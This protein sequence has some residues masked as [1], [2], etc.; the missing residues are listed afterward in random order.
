MNDQATTP[1]RTLPDGR[2]A[3]DVAPSS[4]LLDHDD[5]AT[6]YKELRAGHPVRL[7]SDGHVFIDH[8]TTG[9]AIDIADQR[10]VETKLAEMKD[11]LQMGFLVKVSPDGTITAN[12]SDNTFQYRSDPHHELSPDD[13]A[14]VREAL[15]GGGNVGIRP[16]GTVQVDYPEG[17]Q[18]RQFV[19]D[20]DRIMNELDNQI[21]SGKLGEAARAG[22]GLMIVGGKNG[23]T[24]FDYSVQPVSNTPPIA[25]PADARDPMD[26]TAPAAMQDEAKDLSGRAAG[27]RE[28]A[29][30]EFEKQA[31]DVGQQRDTAAREQGSAQ[32]QA[33]AAHQQVNDEYRQ[34]DAAHAAADAANAQALQLEAAGK[35]AEAAEQHE[36]ARAKLA[37]EVALRDRAGGASEAATG[38]EKQAADAGAKVQQLD[39]QLTDVKARADASEATADAMENRAK[40]MTEAA[41]HLDEANRLKMEAG[42]SRARGNEDEARRIEEN[43]DRER[44]LGTAAVGTARGIS[45]DPITPDPA[46]TQPAGTQPPGTDP[47]TPSDTGAG[48]TPV[49]LPPPI[50][51]DD[52]SSSAPGSDTATVAATATTDALGDPVLSG[53]FASPGDQAVTVAAADGPAPSDVGSDVVSGDPGT[54]PD[55]VGDID[56]PATG[57]P[58][59]DAQLASV[60][61]SP[62]DAAGSLSTDASATFADDTSAGTPDSFAAADVLAAIDPGAAS[63]DLATEGDTAGLAPDPGNSTAGDSTPGDSTPGDSTPGDSTPGDL[64]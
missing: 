48:T 37:E 20:V 18:R 62:A 15:I 41:D 43:A 5:L 46:A 12:S 22:S 50:F 8:N 32:Q 57:A 27:M 54:A 1:R 29:N 42:H 39:T 4:A 2:P 7:S 34:A 11:M 64:A 38:L 10:F 16:D 28:T 49:T 53:A 52:L 3:P 31:A 33:A 40:A 51:G 61:A 21:S 55:L 45:V 9:T 6:M 17:A 56:T 47:S 30:R 25:F 59:A 63:P 58:Q 13:R 35:P 19:D 36:L 26:P 44:Q 23:T 24:E 60:D 14:F